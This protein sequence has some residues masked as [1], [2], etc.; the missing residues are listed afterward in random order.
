MADLVRRAEAGLTAEDFNEI[1]AALPGIGP[2]YLS[3]ILALRFP[4]RYWLLNVQIRRFFEAQGIELRAELPWGKKGNQ[5]EQYM[6]AGRHLTDLRRA[7]DEMADRPVDYMFTD[8]FVYWAN[9]QEGVEALSDPWMERIANW[10]ESDV[11]AE[12]I[13]ARREGESRARALM[14]E[15][16]G[17]FD[18][19]VLRQFLNDLSTDWSNGALRHDRFMPALYGAQVNHMAD[20][21]DGFN[22]WVARLWHAEDEALDDLLDAFWTQLEVSGAGVSLPTAVLYLK[23]PESYC[24]WLPIMSKGLEV[25]TEFEPGKMRTARG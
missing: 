25:A 14:E 17:G 4:D 16:V 6:L 18:E 2:A 1:R 15:K 22:D 12:R 21:L 7:I 9:K 8:L 20:T 5:G 11:P 19:E 3:E 23:D 13:E 24:I 10:Q